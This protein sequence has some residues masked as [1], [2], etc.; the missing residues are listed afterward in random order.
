MPPPATVTVY[1][2]ELPESRHLVHAAV[3]RDDGELVAAIGDPERLT[4][5][6]SAAKP[7]QAQP[8]VA[9]G[10][11]Y[12][13]GLSERSLAVA[14]ASHEGADVHVAAVRE[15]LDAAGLDPELLQ[16]WPGD[17]EARLRHNCSGNH[18]GFLALSSVR[19]WDTS[20]Y[21]D[22]GHP[23]QRAALAAVAEAARVPEARIGTCVDNCGV[24]AFALPLATIASMFARLAA[25]L[26]RQY[27]AMRA[28]PELVRG[29]G[30]FDTELMR[31]LPGAVAK[32]GAEAVQAVGLPEQ[33]LG[34]AVRCEDGAFRAVEPVC[35]A[36]LGSLLGWE[37]PPSALAPFVEPPLQANTGE[38]IGRLIAEVPH[39]V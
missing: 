34:I 18:M 29:E 14:C 37:R 30:G 9:S 19:G 3:V 8:L 15:G 6:R 10:A 38:L 36:L 22:A 33:G 2:G 23:S 20:S 5:L 35:M 28:H 27:A 1:R 32:A 12:E 21:R 7:F 16:N 39:A 26:P 31:A 17:V 24:V 11:A 25:E 13:L 4:T